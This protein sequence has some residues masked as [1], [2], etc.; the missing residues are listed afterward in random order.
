LVT[1]RKGLVMN[2]ISTALVS[3]AAVGAMVATAGCGAIEP[4]ASKADAQAKALPSALSDG[5]LQV[6]TDPTYPPFEYKDA[7]TNEIIGIDPSLAR[8]IAHE[9]GVK[10][11]FKVI[12]FD[13]LIPGLDAGRF[14][15]AMSDIGD[16]KDRRQKVDF[17]D[18]AQTLDVLLVPKGSSLVEAGSMDELCGHSIAAQ[19]GT[20]EIGWLQS[21]SHDCVAK[22]QP[23]IDVKV[24]PGSPQA[25]LALTTDRVDGF[26][27]DSVA[28]NFT[29]KTKA[30]PKLAIAKLRYTYGGLLGIAVP[31]NDVKMRKA[32]SDA[33][34][35]IM[36]DGTYAKLMA[37]YGLADLKLDAPRLNQGK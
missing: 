5:V 23:K 18:Y 8:A 27:S 11:E 2:R 10:I 33:L 12:G 17:V 19:L 3:L 24:F 35:K 36:A 29:M 13:T 14:D 20:L 22:S 32:L 25:L 21:A 30:G 28:A 26:M 7:V 6:A 31:K 1:P 37:K 34:S 16:S 4:V 9:L 15:V